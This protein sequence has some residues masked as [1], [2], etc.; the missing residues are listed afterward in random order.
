MRIIYLAIR[1]TFSELK[2]SAEIFLEKFI[3]III[4]AGVFFI[5]VFFIPLTNSFIEFSKIILFFCLISLA[6]IVWLVKILIT[7]KINI[8]LKSVDSLIFLFLIIYLAASFL[9]IDKYNS[10]IGSNLL[11]THSFVTVLFL[12]IFYFFVSR[13][14]TK[15]KQ[16][17]IIIIALV[18][19]VLSVLINQVL[20]YFD[21]GLSLLNLNSGLN[22][23]NLL[24]LLGLI[25][26]GILYFLSDSMKFK[27]IYLVLGLML[28]LLLFLA[29]KQ[30]I[31]LI[32]SIGIFLFILLLSLKSNYFSNKLVIS[33]TLLL[34]LTVIV[35]V[36]PI[37]NFTGILSPN[38]FDLP[39][40]YGWQITKSSLA[41]NLIFGVGPQNFAYSFFKYKPVDLN[42]TSYW[43]LG[44]NKNSSFWLEV[45]NG[46]G[47]IGF[48]ILISL[49]IKY[50]YNLILYIRTFDIEKNSQYKK[51]IALCLNCV[52]LFSFIIYGFFVNFDFVLI[53]LFVLFAAIGVGLMNI[54]KFEKNI[55]N[56]YL[57]NFVF[58]L[59]LIILVSFIYF[60]S[61]IV[62]AEVAVAEA[63]NMNHQSIEAFDKSQLYMTRAIKI[64]PGNIDYQ[65]DKLNLKIDKLIF[66][67]QNNSEV[68]L[69][70]LTE[71]IFKDLKDLTNIKTNRIG[72]YFD[73]WQTTNKLKKLGFP[74]EN[75]QEEINTKLIDFDSNNPELYID[76]ALINF[77]KHSIIS[78]GGIEVADKDSQVEILSEKI[79]N[80]LEKSI[81]LKPDYVLG[82]YNLGLY[83]QKFG[84]QELAIINI[85]KAFELEPSQK[86]IVLS[87]KKL[88]LNQDKVAEA[89]VVLEK[90]LESKPGDQDILNMLNEIK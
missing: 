33:L 86:L 6:I 87:L 4:Y 28:L 23:F 45:F 34:F 57:V 79:L 81:E 48:L 1:N 65:L 56:K 55:T 75:F 29:D 62:Y 31:L 89:K 32:L 66:L 35:L 43:Q 30:I 69:I 68:S 25:L 77:N 50:F 16:F 51:F 61:K 24:I 82:Y 26:L 18:I 46:V 13:F 21:Y 12:A 88:Y 15:I 3:R 10:F 27:G 14:I 72:F 49:V 67:G 54:I 19:S 20:Q 37:S 60:G 38:E 53:F 70:S 90:Y 85:A 58:Y 84:D 80:D 59:G 2:S 11:I 39:Q 83:W 17:K 74:V 8:E 40:Y 71:E 22:S 9:A 42:L 76:R 73:L 63:V 47:L 44:F 52:I 5:P 78:S 41:E 7:K 36:L 64:N